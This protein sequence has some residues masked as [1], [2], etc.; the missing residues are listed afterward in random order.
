M[1]DL[2]GV[3]LLLIPSDEEFWLAQYIMDEGSIIFHQLMPLFSYKDL[4]VNCS[5]QLLLQWMQ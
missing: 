1:G 5:A 2:I 4:R 3:E